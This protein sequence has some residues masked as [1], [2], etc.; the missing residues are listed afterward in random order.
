MLAN[1]EFNF[2]MMF[3]PAKIKPFKPFANQASSSSLNLPATSIIT[4]AGLPAKM[5]G[6]NAFVWSSLA[7]ITT[8][9]ASVAFNQ[10]KASSTVVTGSLF[11]LEPDPSCSRNQIRNQHAVLN[12]SRSLKLKYLFSH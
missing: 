11:F 1:T 12:F 5:A 10:A 7:A 2:S 3:C 6:T 4:S 8:Y 9:L